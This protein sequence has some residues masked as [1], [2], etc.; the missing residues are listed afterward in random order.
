MLLVKLQSFSVLNNRAEG[1]IS[2][3][4]SKSYFNG[5]GINLQPTLTQEL[6][7]NVIT[8]LVMHTQILLECAEF[9][10]F[11]DYLIEDIRSRVSHY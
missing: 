9:S 11:Y 4:A 3:E 8:M 10:L 6:R 1:N 7:M 2:V 5:N